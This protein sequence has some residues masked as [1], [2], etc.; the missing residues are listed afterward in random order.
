MDRSCAVHYINY[1]AYATGFLEWMRLTQD[2][3]NP[4]ES[5]HTFDPRGEILIFSF[6]KYSGQP[7]PKRFDP[8]RPRRH[9]FICICFL[10]GVLPGCAHLPERDSGLAGQRRRRA[11]RRTRAP[12]P[13]RGAYP[14]RGQSETS[15]GGPFP[16][17]IVNRNRS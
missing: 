4:E 10:R 12:T 1:E 15:N 6:I 16:P 17:G 13:V 9:P 14:C 7:R 8:G 3:K 5:R 11:D 2:E